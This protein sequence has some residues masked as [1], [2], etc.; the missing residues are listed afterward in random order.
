MVMLMSGP[1]PNAPG[2][3]ES[4][5]HL[6]VTGILI[7]VCLGLLVR[8]VSTPVYFLVGALFVVS[9]VWFAQQGRARFG[10][11]LGALL[12]GLAIISVGVAHYV[13]SVP[14]RHNPVQDQPA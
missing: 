6:L 5:S 4:S 12:S 2:K 13:T 7:V 8:Q 9:A 1:T 10:L 11:T 14:L 3:E